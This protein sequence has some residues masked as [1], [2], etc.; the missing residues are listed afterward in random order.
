MTRSPRSIVGFAVVLAISTC[1]AP[2]AFA[3]EPRDAKEAARSLFEAGMDH[4]KAKR[5]QRALEAFLKSRSVYPTRFN[6]QNAALALRHLGRYSEAIDLLESMAR[7]FPNATRRDQ[8]V[9]DRELRE[10]EA[11]V[12]MLRIEGAPDGA[13]VL[14][15]G[16]DKGTTPLGRMIRVDEGRRRVRVT[17]TGFEPFEVE[18]AISGGQIHDVPLRMVPKLGGGRLR[19]VERGGLEAEVWLDGK[20]VGSTPWEGE[21][22]PG[23]HTVLLKHDASRGTEP[24]SIEVSR[25]ETREVVLEVEE[26]P[27]AVV[28]RADPRTAELEVDGARVGT[29]TWRGR[30]KCSEHTVRASQAGREPV[31]RD[32]LPSRLSTTEITLDRLGAPGED[33]ERA[34]RRWFVAAD[35]GGFVAESVGG[36]FGEACTSE[37]CAT[38]VG[39]IPLLR[40]GRHL[41]PALGLGLEAGYL[42]FTAQ[43]T[44]RDGN[45][46][47]EQRLRGGL[48]GGA[49]SHRTPDRLHGVFRFAAGVL[50]ARVELDDFE[51]S[52]TYVYFAPEIRVAYSVSE[53]LEL[54]VAVRSYFMTG[55]EPTIRPEAPEGFSGS[56]EPV[57]L[58]DGFLWLFTPAI[59]ARYGFP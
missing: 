32:F 6:T 47:A 31:S 46:E 36:V 14:V 52:L 2:P 15:D 30:L 10:L 34:Y 43:Y 9:V 1:L 57:A 37:S 56:L 29:G 18:I 20:L 45:V 33:R 55:S 59:G 44:D 58:T 54:S 28:L 51:G 25:G 19:V 17:R 35:F 4:V 3:D 21:V 53:S 23:D 22:A 11:R 41:S 5:W 13:A 38:S 24:G 40:G 8:Q 49:I 16:K 27:C 42:G 12:G 50:S 48:L 39:V 7:E 26:L